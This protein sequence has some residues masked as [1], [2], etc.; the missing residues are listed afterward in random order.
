M[1]TDMSAAQFAK[2]MEFIRTD[3]RETVRDEI[4]KEM[5]GIYARF[6]QIDARFDVVFGALDKDELEI[7][8]LGMKADRHEKRLTTLEKQKA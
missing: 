6:D 7:G 8:A 4:R 2:L 3:V 1:N 5:A